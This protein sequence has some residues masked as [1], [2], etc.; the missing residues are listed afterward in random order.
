MC[1]H[2]WTTRELVL[3]TGK[4]T[5][6]IRRFFSALWLPMVW[7]LTWKSVFL[8]PPPSKFL[9]TRFRQQERPPRPITPPKS[10]IAHPPGHQAAAM[11]SRHG[12]LLPP[13]FAKLCSS[14]EAFD[15]SPE[16]GGGA[17]NFA[18]DRHR[19]GGFP[20]GQMPPGSG[21]RFLFQKTHRHRVSLFNF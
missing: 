14:F 16:G 1:L 11:F 12:Q 13:L 2:T 9:A 8:Q 4:H 7:Q 17:Q 20:E 21:I 10:K 15:R 18:M 5:S 6:A 19:S 3:R